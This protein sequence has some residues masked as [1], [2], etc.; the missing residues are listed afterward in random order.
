MA[1]SVQNA[2]ANL[3]YNLTAMSVVEHSAAISSLNSA[4]NL[5]AKLSQVDLMG[6]LADN[7]A[8]I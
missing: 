1:N 4:T 2:V 5:I 8:V 7:L 3:S 6:T